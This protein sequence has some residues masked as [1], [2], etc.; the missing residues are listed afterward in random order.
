MN[1]EQIPK[2]LDKI[3]LQADSYHAIGAN[4][5]EQKPDTPE[6]PLWVFIYAFEY[7]YIEVTNVDYR[8]RYGIYG[9]W[10]ELENRVF[11]PPLNT[12]QENQF[13]LIESVLKTSEN[14]LVR[15][16]LSDLL[17]VARWGESPHLLASIAIDEYLI[18]HNKGLSDFEN[19]SIL[20]RALEIAREINQKKEQC[21]KAITEASKKE[22]LQNKKQPGISL[23]LIQ[24]LLNLPKAEVPD[25]IDDL[26]D[27]AYKK[28][29]DDPWITQTIFEM[30][31]PRKELEEQKVLRLK[32]IENWIQESKKNNGVAKI[33]ELNKALEIARNFGFTSKVAEIRKEIES[34]PESELGLK[35]LSVSMNIPKARIEE[36]IKYFI[37][38]DSWV[39]SLARFGY[40]G[41]PSGKFEENQ[42]LAER[43]QKKAPLQF[44]ISQVVLDENN[45][46]LRFGKSIEDNRDLTII[47]Q[48]TLGISLFG[49]YAPEI[50]TKIKEKHGRITLNQLVKIFTTPLITAEDAKIIAQGIIWFYRKEYFISAHLLVPRIEAVLRN[51][52]R[53]LDLPIIREPNGDSPGGVIQLGTILHVLKGKIDESWRRYYRN[54]LC[55]PIGLNLRNRICHG[56]DAEISDKDCALLIQI[57]CNLR[58]LAISPKQKNK[59]VV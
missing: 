9:P 21:I 43:I 59:E 41:P 49:L 36:F 2:L 35:E 53:K 51:I 4:L 55:E 17:W 16:R 22:I 52:A 13:S 23:R 19:A 47:R 40:H 32:L 45:A 37:N 14:S 31:I 25:S 7:I 29:Q 34:I 20:I 18:L 39:N 33:F 44:L 56:L 30:M 27:R 57:V 24:S 5:R 12:L 6:H 28:Y 15:S 48:E 46:P 42:K 58:L 38:V 1:N 11:P 26:I 50:L 8:K 3:A 10:I 54:V